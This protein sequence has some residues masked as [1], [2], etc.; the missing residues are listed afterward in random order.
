MNKNDEN[1]PGGEGLPTIEFE[2]PRGI[3]PTKEVSIQ[4]SNFELAPVSGKNTNTKVSEE[5]IKRPY[6]GKITLDEPV[7][8][9]IKRDLEGIWKKT[10]ITF[11][12]GSDSD[13]LKE[14]KR[15]DLWG[16]FLFTI[17][18]AL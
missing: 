16:P 18:Y 3:D 11:M 6:E 12:Y 7:S 5:H 2:T 1:I 15:Y 14:L 10:K 4:P 13:K 9:T 17:T 8:L